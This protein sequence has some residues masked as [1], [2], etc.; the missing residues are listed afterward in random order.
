MGK[1]FRLTTLP[2]LEADLQRQIVDYL[3]HE[4][5][6]G[7]IGWFC[8]VN[9][10]MAKRAGGGRMS[11]YRLFLFGADETSAGYADLHGTYGPR[12][13]HPGR[14]WALEVKKPGEPATEAQIAFLESVRASGGVAATVWSY[15]DAKNVL[16]AEMDVWK[17][18][19]EREQS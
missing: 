12:S 16:F 14:Y 1:P 11:F 17:I 2:V 10:G 8:R 5:A 15:D 3:R 13:A 9:S 7:R 19:N 18:E 4:Q 6:R